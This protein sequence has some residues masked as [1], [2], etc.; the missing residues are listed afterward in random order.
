MSLVALNNASSPDIEY[1]FFLQVAQT[2]CLYAIAMAAARS[3]FVRNA[4]AF[5]NLIFHS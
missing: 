4:K 3:V 2:C 5:P 1:D